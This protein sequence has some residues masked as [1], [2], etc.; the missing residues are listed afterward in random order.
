MN[1][2]EKTGFRIID[3][4]QPVIIRDSR[5]IL[6]YS[7]EDL[8]PRVESFN[9]PKGSYI[10][11]RGAFKKM[12]EPIDYKLPSLPP[13]E[14]NRP[15]PIDF[16]VIFGANKHKCSILWDAQKILFDTSLEDDPLPTLMFMLYHEF[17]H[18]KY[19][20][21]KY[22]DLYASNLMIKKGYNPSQIARA[23]ILS[24]SNRQKN[25]K[26]FLSEKIIENYG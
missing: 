4:S 7:T 24:L 25:R 21:E 14:R 11:D 1:L 13:F 20:T 19:K 12:S 23:Q 26:E 17:G 5:G 15:V 2:T 10:V 18:S 22:C 9:L 16:E 8:L 3:K 6:F